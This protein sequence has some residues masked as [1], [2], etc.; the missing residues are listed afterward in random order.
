MDQKLDFAL[1]TRNVCKSVTSGGYILEILKDINFSV[2]SGESVAILGASGAG[3]TTL[4]TLL[5]GLDVPTKGEIFLENH[6]LS[7]LNEDERAALRLKSIGFVFQSFQLLPELT[8]LEN[9]CLPLEIQGYA[10]KTAKQQALQCLSDVG[11]SSRVTHYPAELSG[12]EQQRVAI[13]RAYVTNPKIIFADEITGNLDQQTGEKIIELF[14]EI[15]QKYHT[16][17]IMVTHDQRLSERAE[18]CYVLDNSF[19]KLL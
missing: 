13:A 6:L 9:V 10:I 5:A 2:K 19:L 12:G 14:F 11:L 16:T 17:L 4:L 7:S 3:K 8:A 18:K 15:N 1:E